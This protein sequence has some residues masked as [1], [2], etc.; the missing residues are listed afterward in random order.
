MKTLNSKLLFAALQVADLLLTLACFHSGL[1]EMNPVTGRLILTFGILGGLIIS[2]L[3]ACAAVLPMKKLVWVGNVAY[4]FIVA[5]NCF[6]AAV[7]GLA[8]VLT[9]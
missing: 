6:L 3:L 8:K 5:W 9:S 1:I 2:K 4:F 7:F